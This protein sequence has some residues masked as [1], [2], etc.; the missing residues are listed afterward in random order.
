[1]VFHHQFWEL[2]KREI[3]ASVRKFQKKPWNIKF[4]SSTF[5]V[6]IPKKE[7]AASIN[8]HMP[9]SLLNGTYKI[10][11]KALARRLKELIR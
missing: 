6:L 8:D 9:I 7:C 11:T 10:I 1:M 2:I 4:L 5:V 3:M